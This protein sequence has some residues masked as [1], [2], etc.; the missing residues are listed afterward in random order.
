M[1][2]IVIF[3]YIFQL[4]IPITITL[5]VCKGPFRQQER[6][7]AATTTSDQQQ[8]IFYTHHPTDRI[9][10]T[11]TFVTPVVEHRLEREI[12]HWVHHEGLIQGRI[13]P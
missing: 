6:K 5:R 3:Q 4:Q 11:M 2:H 8:G 1:L 12:A 7:P 9:S 10:H 13:A